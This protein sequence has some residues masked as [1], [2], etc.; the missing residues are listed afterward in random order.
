MCNSQVGTDNLQALIEASQEAATQG[1]CMFS[2]FTDAA[3][4]NQNLYHES[5]CAAPTF[6]DL[7]VNNGGTNLNEFLEDHK[8]IGPFIPVS[9]S[10][11]FGRDLERLI[12]NGSRRQGL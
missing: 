9:R 5:V 10:H 7:D 3:G 11:R 8:E 1:W 2:G 12:A 4:I 6:Y